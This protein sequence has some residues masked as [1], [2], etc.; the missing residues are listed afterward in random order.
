MESRYTP[1]EIEAKWQKAWA[2]KNLDTTP[3]DPSKPK[4]YA[5][6]MFSLPIGKPPCGSHP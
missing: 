4:F 5:L 6:S 3:E 2:E 1:V